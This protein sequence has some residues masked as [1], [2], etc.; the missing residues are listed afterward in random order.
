MASLIAEAGSTY[1]LGNFWAHMLVARGAVDLAVSMGGKDWD[2]AAPSLIVREAG[3]KFS[4]LDGNQAQVSGSA[5][6]SNSA[7]H[8]VAIEKMRRM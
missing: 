8:S 4:D 6:S 5:V 3:G 2:Y 7:L 1:G